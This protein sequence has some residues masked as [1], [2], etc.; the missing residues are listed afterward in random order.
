M[1]VTNAR[2]VLVTPTSYEFRG[3]LDSVSQLQ[4]RRRRIEALRQMYVDALQAGDTATQTQVIADAGKEGVELFQHL[5]LSELNEVKQIEKLAS[6]LAANKEVLDSGRNLVL[7]KDIDVAALLLKLD[8]LQRTNRLLEAALIASTAVAVNARTQQR[9]L[10]DLDSSLGSESSKLGDLTG[11]AAALLV[12]ARVQDTLLRLRT[13]PVTSYMQNAPQ[14][15]QNADDALQPLLADSPDIGRALKDQ[16]ADARSQYGALA[17]LESD[18]MVKKLRRIESTLDAGQAPSTD[19][20][21]WL[22]RLVQDN[23]NLPPVIVRL[24]ARTGLAKPAESSRFGELS[25]KWW[26]EWQRISAQKGIIAPTEKERLLGELDKSITD[27]K[28]SANLTGTDLELW[29]LW[30]V[31]V[32]QAQEMAESLKPYLSHPAPVFDEQKYDPAWRVLGRW[33]EQAPDEVFCLFAGEWLDA[34]EN[35]QSWNEEII[36]RRIAKEK[37]AKQQAMADEMRAR[38]APVRQSET[39]RARKKQERGLALV[40]QMTESP[41]AGPNPSKGRLEST[42]WDSFSDARNNPNSDSGISGLGIYPTAGNTGSQW[43]SGA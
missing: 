6:T 31:R 30:R 1:D 11:K 10:A 20:V 40:R 35:L 39:E 36:N 23:A 13:A 43:Q 37:K 26:G 5:P 18:D 2:R 41:K 17:R 29:R 19:D 33:L 32:G 22:D 25:A 9:E 15:F 4:E 8:E 21:N 24:L 16:L 28:Q 14:W 7:L 12:C 42:S 3:L 27:L 38:L 34:H